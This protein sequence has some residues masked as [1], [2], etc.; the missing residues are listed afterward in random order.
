MHPRKRKELRVAAAWAN[1][2][3]RARRHPQPNKGIS[4]TCCSKIEGRNGAGAAQGRTGAAEK[5]GV[6]AAH[7][8]QRNDD[9]GGGAAGRNDDDGGRRPNR[10]KTEELGAIQPHAARG[11]SNDGID[12]AHVVGNRSRAKE[13]RVAIDD[14]D[15]SVPYPHAADS[16]SHVCWPWRRVAPGVFQK[17]V[18]CCP[19]QQQEEQQHALAWPH[20]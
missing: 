19:R 4:P 5:V 3:A 18:C 12:V 20:L 8:Q 6:D 11:D 15:E 17:D 2:E 14:D 1:D 16:H 7:G 13:A 10:K 9:G